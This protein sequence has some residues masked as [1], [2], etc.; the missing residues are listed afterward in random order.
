MAAREP[1]LSIVMPVWNGERYLPEALE[2]VRREGTDGYE[3]IAVDDGSSDGSP[4]ILRAWERLLPLRRIARDRGGNWV[5]ATNAGLREARGKYACFLHQDDLWFPGRL[6]AI[7]R[8]AAFG[9]ALVLHP[10]L[11]VGPGGNRLG[12]WR[13]PLPAGEV[14]P[15]LFAE[16]LIVQ[17][18]IAAPAP[19]FAREAALRAGA[20]D[21]SLW[22]TADWDFWLRL[23]RAG[24]IRYFDSPLAGFRVHAGSQTVVR[25]DLADRRRQL[26]AVLDRH[27]G[28]APAAARRAARFSLELNLAL[29]AAA[30]GTAVRWPPVVGA[31]ARLGPVGCARYVRDSRIVERIRARLHLRGAHL[32]GGAGG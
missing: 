28:A 5:A 6:A 12:P 29:A 18:F 19:V 20:M 17:N 7:Q 10:A 23:G 4:E 3:V 2:S 9:P 32:N 1:W 24:A 22:Y 16:R 14:D 8:E 21:E 25:T 27:G 26:E 31:L 30:S 15:A 11:Y 13:C